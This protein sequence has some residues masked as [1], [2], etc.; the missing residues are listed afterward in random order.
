MKFEIKDTKEGGY[1]LY[2]K[3]VIGLIRLGDI[4]LYKQNKKNESR[5]WQSEWKINYHEIKKA[6]CGKVGY[7][8]N[9]TPNRILVIQMN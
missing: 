9:F 3:S 1:R 7:G 2:D 5:C 4:E 8:G 6:L